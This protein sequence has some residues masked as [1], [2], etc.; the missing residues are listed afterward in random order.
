MT[1]LRGISPC[2]RWKIS[3]S[4]AA[5]SSP[6]ASQKVPVGLSTRATSAAHWR[7][8]SRYTLASRRSS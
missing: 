8:Q 2:S 1:Q 6:M 3:F 4:S 5:N 7:D